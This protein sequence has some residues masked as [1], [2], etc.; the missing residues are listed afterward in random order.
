MLRFSELEKMVEYYILTDAL[1]TK[2]RINKN[3]EFEKHMKN[4]AWITDASSYNYLINSTFEPCEWVPKIGEKYYSP[5]PVS[6]CGLLSSSGVW[7][8]DLADIQT[9]KNVGIHRTAEKAHAKSLEMGW[10]L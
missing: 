3:G 1:R 7:A 8:N 10:T 9:N 5:C 2:V 4:G 6:Y